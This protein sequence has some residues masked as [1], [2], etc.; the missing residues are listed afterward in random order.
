MEIGRRT[1]LDPSL[2]ALVHN[3]LLQFSLLVV[4]ERGEVHVGGVES[5]GIHFEWLDVKNLFGEVGIDGS[6]E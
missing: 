3:K 1:V 4:V 2:L 5:C 6:V